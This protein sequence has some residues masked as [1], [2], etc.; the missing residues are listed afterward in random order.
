[1][2][3]TGKAIRRGLKSALRAAIWGIL[4]KHVPSGKPDIWVFGSR[5]SGTTLLMQIIAANPGVKFANQPMSLLSS[6][7]YDI[8]LVPSFE[9]GLF[10]EFYPELGEQLEG[11]FGAI[12]AGKHHVNEQWRPWY[13]D[14]QFRSDRIVFKMTDGQLLADWFERTFGGATIFLVRHP[15]S[16][17]ASTIRNKWGYRHRNYLRTPSFTER[18]LAPPALRR[19]L[20]IEATGSLVEQH[21]LTWCCEN[22]SLIKQLD[23]CPQRGFISYEDLAIRPSDVV[24]GLHQA[25]DLPD[26]DAMSRAA[27]RVSLSA[28]GKNTTQTTR[29][30]IKE[31]DR[32]ALISRWRKQLSPDDETAAFRVLDLFEIDLY[33]PGSDTPKRPMR[34]P[35]PKI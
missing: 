11:F 17:S 27:G 35:K 26:V 14:F 7:E 22:V 16:Q 2:S 13:P 10:L 20:E 12:R 31:G 9:N 24:E 29:D 28:R 30:A 4:N 3:H 15:L 6:S 23:H 8:A 18:Y 1:M 32:S 34:F 19:C 25:Y 21:V 33:G 5:R